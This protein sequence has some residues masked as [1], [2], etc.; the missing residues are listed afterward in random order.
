MNIGNRYR[1]KLWVKVENDG[2]LTFRINGTR[3]EVLKAFVDGFNVMFSHELFSDYTIKK[4]IEEIRQDAL[5][6][7]TN[8]DD[9]EQYGEAD[10]VSLIPVLFPQRPNEIEIRQW[11]LDYTDSVTEDK[12]NTIRQKLFP[13]IKVNYTAKQSKIEYTNNDG[14]IQDYPVYF[15]G[16]LGGYMGLEEVEAAKQFVSKL[17]STVELN[18]SSK[19][20]LATPRL[21]YNSKTRFTNVVGW[22]QFVGDVPGGHCVSKYIQFPQGRSH[23]LYNIVGRIFHNTNPTHDLHNWKYPYATHVSGPSGTT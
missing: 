11:A 3:S 14:G 8:K 15:E 4:A 6:I 1:Q 21:Y 20:P 13:N 17:V 2:R 18:K 5:L 16:L 10:E 19:L 22:N 23:A 7:I 12:L 9:Y